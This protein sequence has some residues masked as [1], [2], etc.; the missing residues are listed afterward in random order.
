MRTILLLPL[1]LAAAAAAGCHATPDGT[2]QTAFSVP[3]RDLTL[4]QTETPQVEVA[5]PVELG[6][7]VAE[8]SATHRAPRSTRSRPAPRLEAAPPSAAPAAM[9]GNVGRRSHATRQRRHLDHIRGAPI[10]TRSRPGS[11]S[12][13]SR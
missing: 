13:S 9:A 4:Q 2:E 6:R 10:P 12:P 1:A 3:A 11:P 5:S 7:P 8:R